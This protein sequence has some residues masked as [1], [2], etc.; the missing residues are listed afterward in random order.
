MGNSTMGNATMTD[1][2][3]TV[4]ATVAEAMDVME[5]P[6]GPGGV[7]AGAPGGPVRALEVD[8]PSIDERDGAIDDD[9]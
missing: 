5:G 1:L 7:D 3:A 2:E 8:E 6:G 4:N 9:E